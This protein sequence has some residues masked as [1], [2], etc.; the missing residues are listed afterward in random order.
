MSDNK[1]VDL[2][3]FETGLKFLHGLQS[4]TVLCRQHPVTECHDQRKHEQT[5]N[6]EWWSPITTPQHYNTLSK[7]AKKSIGMVC[8]TLDKFV[9]E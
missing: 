1:A 3:N 6:K 5:N 9:I 8:E 7:S 4:V 2:P